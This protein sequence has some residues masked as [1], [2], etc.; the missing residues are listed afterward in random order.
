MTTPINLTP[1]YDKFAVY[2]PA[3]QTQFARAVAKKGKKDRQMPSGITMRDL[4]FLN[5]KSKLWHFGYALY[6]VGQFSVGEL[7][8]DAVNNWTVLTLPSLFTQPFG[9]EP[10]LGRSGSNCPRF[11]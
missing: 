2:L 1:H 8:G 11:S 3:L 9:L 10:S 7:K 5:P 6:S 4:D